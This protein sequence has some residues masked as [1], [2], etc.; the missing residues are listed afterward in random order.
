[1]MFVF[2]PDGFAWTSEA[3]RRPKDFDGAEK[4]IDLI[5]VKMVFNL[6]SAK[7]VMATGQ[8]RRR[9]IRVPCRAVPVNCA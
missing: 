9:R 5:N 8:R 3:K 2:A 6:T 7:T 1:M 4:G